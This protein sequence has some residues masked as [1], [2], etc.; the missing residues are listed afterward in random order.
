[1]QE[2][3]RRLHGAEGPDQRLTKIY[4]DNSLPSPAPRT[5]PSPKPSQTNTFVAHLP[6]ASPFSL[7]P[8]TRLCILSSGNLFLY[9][10]YFVKLVFFYI[11]TTDI[12]EEPGR[13]QNGH[14][15]RTHTHI[16]ILRN[17]VLPPIGSYCHS[18]DVF[19]LTKH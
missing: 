16:Y 7:S 4:S 11:Y 17:R 10:Y 1:M 2:T 13:Y 6:S 15:S 9:I 8:R 14:E 18:T 12:A 3:L 19:R 5:P